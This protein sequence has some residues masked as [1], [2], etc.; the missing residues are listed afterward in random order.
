MDADFPAAH[1]M[2][3]QWFAIDRDGH[4]GIFSSGESGAVPRAA[5]VLRDEWDEEGLWA[6]L[7]VVPGEPLQDLAGYVIPGE[8]TNRDDGHAFV[9]G[10]GNSILMFLKSLDP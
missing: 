9:D 6:S 2:D 1:S 4:V 5:G 7:E 8:S 10:D 3:T